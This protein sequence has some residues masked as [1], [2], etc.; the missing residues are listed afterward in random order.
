LLTNHLIGFL[1][2]LSG[3]PVP[4][5]HRL[6]APPWIASTNPRHRRAGIDG[7]HRPATMGEASPTS[8]VGCHPKVDRPNNLARPKPAAGVD[9]HEQ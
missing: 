7:R 3:L 8:G 6:H 5:P 9:L 4:T 1:D 2:L